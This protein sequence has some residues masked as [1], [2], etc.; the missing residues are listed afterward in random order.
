[1]TY[2]THG[3]LGPKDEAQVKADAIEET[4]G[5][6]WITAEYGPDMGRDNVY[7]G[8]RVKFFSVKALADLGFKKEGT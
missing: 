8:H 2:P 7:W 3:F 4:G 1:V 6:A 5:I